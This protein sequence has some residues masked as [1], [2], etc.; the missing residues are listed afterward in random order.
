M[1]AALLASLVAAVTGLI[2]FR[3]EVPLWGL[4]S[5]GS[6][7]LILVGVTSLAAATIEHVRFPL[8]TVPSWSPAVLRIQRTVN[9]ASIALVHAGIA[10]MV[11]GLTNAVLVQSLAGLKLDVFT[12]TMIVVLLS[13]GA[14]YGVTLSAGDVTI[15]RLS[16]LFAVFMTG[17]VVVAMLTTTEAQWWKLHFSE[18]G[19]GSGLSGTIFNGTLIL[20]GFLLASLTTLVA[21]A[22]AQWASISPPSRYRNVRLVSWAFGIIGVCLAGAGVVP[23]DAGAF[24]HVTLAAGVAVVFGGVLIGLRWILDGFSRTFL[25]FSDVALAGLVISTLLF[26][27]IRYYNLAAYELVAGGIIFAWLVIFMRH[28][29]ASTGSHDSG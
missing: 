20:S 6:I 27:P 5:P 29:A 23:E 17:G 12:S 7:G 11:V 26:W 18:L 1:T 3:G 25:L 9:V 10:L 21:P 13:A 4:V 19:A 22:L 2:V 24:V 8:P 16:T 14:A 15:T 28:V